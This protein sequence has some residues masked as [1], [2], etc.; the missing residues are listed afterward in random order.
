MSFQTPITIASALDKIDK[1]QYLLPAIQ[2]EFEWEHTR[3]EWLFDSIM[4]GYPISSFL[5]WNVSENTAKNYK[6]YKFINSYREF[7]KTHNEEFSTNGINSFQ[8]ILDGQQR[9]TSLYIGLKGSYAYKEYRKKWENTEYSI[10]TRHLYLNVTQPL[11]DD[12]EGRIY[13][14]SFLKQDDTNLSEL[15]DYQ[16]NYWFKVS[17]I[18][19]YNSASD[20]DDFIDNIDE[21]IKEREKVKFAKKSIRQL[22][23]SIL[24]DKLINYFLE[25]EQSL[26]KALNIFIRINSGAKPLS[27]S[28]LLMSIAVANWEVKDA[29][30]EIHQ[31]VDN[32][33]EKGFN[34]SKDLILKTY[35]YLYSR[36]IKFRVT[37]FSKQNAQ[38][39]EAEWEQIRN[40]IL[41][42]FNLLKT[43]GFNEVT[44]TSKNAVLPIIYYLFHSKKYE[45]FSNK[46][47]YKEDRENIKNWL[48]KV[49]IKQVFGGTSDNT[50][51]QIR[52][53]FT[54]DFDQYYLNQDIQQFPLGEI[55]NLIKKDTAINQEFIEDLLNSQMENKYT[56][57]IL[58]LLY[59]N[60][61]YK[62]NNFHKDHIHPATSFKDLSLEN[63]S[64]YDWYAYNSICNLQM[65]DANENMSKNGKSLIEWVDLETESKD[66]VTFLKNHLI[67][68][69]DLELNNFD[70]YFQ[71]RKSL[72]S[73]KLL[74]L[75]I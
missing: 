8:A 19:N 70:Q 16:N 49:L 12:E 20:L 34:I 36:D 72:L 56:F 58:S 25:E 18:L 30:K 43:F 59:P 50:L 44:L 65:L 60:L 67:P 51:S 48:H 26:D 28:D 3:I 35:L 63:K 64:K 9:L 17:K 5:F 71:S 68:N 41:E 39:F 7:Y 69:I 57:S 15:F 11:T 73:T 53:A 45:S 47:C 2:R 66:R 52:K 37:N 38:K 33:R 22:R 24:E 1:N 23:K 10:P 21:T 74:E 42:T 27:F 29:R 32:I 40:T 54:E 61:D 55:L 14:F 62:N 31:L 75:L 13:N 46:T 4:R 6:F